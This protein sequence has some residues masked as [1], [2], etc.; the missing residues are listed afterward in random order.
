MQSSRSKSN[1]QSQEPSAKSESAQLPQDRR[2]HPVPDATQQAHFPSVPPPKTPKTPT[3]P[4]QQTVQL[5]P[6]QHPTKRQTTIITEYFDS[7]AAPAQQ[8]A[9]IKAHD[10]PLPRSR[11]ATI[12]LP[13]NSAFQQ[14]ILALAPAN[15][16]HVMPHDIPL[17]Y[18]RAPTMAGP[19]TATATSQHPSSTPL[20][21][22]HPAAPTAYD[23]SPG[24]LSPRTDK[25]DKTSRDRRMRLNA[26]PL[27]NMPPEQIPPH[28]LRNMVMPSVSVIDYALAAPLPESR[29]TTMIGSPTATR[30]LVSMTCGKGCELMTERSG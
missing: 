13:P 1:V 30:L 23:G 27:M 3:V 19:T 5:E 4:G 25:T 10:I 17:P 9:S 21:L 7:P 16:T 6:A 24:L 28:I 22:S 8:L 14:P 2:H 29:G 18:S 20:P 12:T 11:A 26:T 15:E